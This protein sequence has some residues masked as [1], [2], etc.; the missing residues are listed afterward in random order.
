M[1]RMDWDRVRRER[2]LAKADDYLFDQGDP[3]LP[4]ETRSPNG[5]PAASRKS[6][7]G[8]GTPRRWSKPTQTRN[9]PG[10]HRIRDLGANDR[11]RLAA[12]RRQLDLATT[13]R[14]PERIQALTELVNME[15]ARLKEEAR[16]SAEKVQWEFE[17]KSSKSRSDRIWHWAIPSPT[18]GPSTHSDRSTH[19]LNPF[20]N[21]L[22]VCGEPIDFVVRVSPKRPQRMV[23]GECLRRLDQVSAQHRQKRSRSSSGKRR[24][25]VKVRRRQDGGK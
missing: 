16:L 18:A 2:L 17:M 19:A 4:Q 12:L 14:L 5:R 13:R 7:T 8:K 10:K 21:G 3:G 6:G 25:T 22:A 24:P 1:T 11:A 23:C 20:R 9:K 15:E